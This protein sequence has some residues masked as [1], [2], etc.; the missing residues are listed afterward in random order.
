MSRPGAQPAFGKI[1]IA[2]RGE[3]ALRIAR[4]CRELGIASVAVY[5]TADATSAVADLADEAV[6]VGPA[7]AGHSY[8]S[9]PA[10]IEAA[11]LTGADAIHPG[12]GFLAENPDFSQV[13][14][15]EG[16]TFIGPS[17][18]VLERFGDK[19][20][21]RDLMRDVGLPLLP[22]GS[23]VCVDEAD[24]AHTAAAIGLP[25]IVKAVAGGGGKGMAVAWRMED[26]ALAVRETRAAA[27]SLYADNRV[28]V[29]RF[30]RRARHVEVQVLADRYGA[31]VHLG[32]RD[33]SVQRRHQK[34]VEETPAPLLA[35]D[36]RRSMAEAALAGVKAAGLVG[37]ATVEFL[38]DEQENFYFMEVNARLQV[39]HAVTEMVTGV[40]IVAQQ[41]RLAAGAPLEL[42]QSSIVARG[43][44]IECRL[45]AEDPDRDFRPTPGTL[46]RVRLP[47]GTFTRVDSH[48]GTGTTITADYDSLLGKVVVWA[49]NREAAVSRL[50]RALDEVVIEGPGVHHTGGL[51][52]R[53]LDDAEFRSASHATDLMPRLLAGP[54]GAPD[55]E[56]DR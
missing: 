22:G 28:Y 44:A 36:T 10:I 19:A 54:S 2:N 46:T 12:Y 45:N 9:I 55:Q 8:A 13:C 3:I 15:D 14:A 20:A 27:Q 1:L 33:C 41:I 35:D 25:I 52:R 26:V 48:I 11:R 16:I 6:C 37:A 38:V 31:A 42:E 24:A 29:E 49:P 21:A 56:S 34:L 23:G 40:D 47:G 5:S 53:V 43:A 32:D 39:E 51:L 17:A 18:A 30:L 50:Q 4:T 7:A